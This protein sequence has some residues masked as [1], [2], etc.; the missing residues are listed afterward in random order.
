M[1]AEPITLT[2][3]RQHY[4]DRN[5]E[6]RR[7]HVAASRVLPGGNTRTLLFQPPFPLTFVRGEGS[8]LEDADGHR[9]VDLLGDY[10]AG[11]LGHSDHRARNAAF[12]ALATNMSVGGIHPIET[13]LA[14]LMCQRWELGLVRFTNSGTEANLMAISAA[15]M[16]TGRTHV[17]V[18]EGAYHGGVLYFGHGPAAWNAPYPVVLGQFNDLAA[19]RRAIA[20]AG[21]QLAAVLVEPMMGSAGCV[22]PADGF[23]AGLVDAAHEVGAVA[24]FDEVMTSRLGPHGLSAMS[25]VQP[26]LKTFGKYIAGGFS[27]G[28]FGGSA[29]V[30]SIFDVTKRGVLPHAGTFNN[31]V[32]SLAAAVEVLRNVYTSD[33][34]DTFTQRGDEFRAGVAVVLA[35]HDLPLCVTGVGTMMNLHTRREPPADGATAYRRNEALQEQIYLGLLERGFYVAPRLMINLS[36]PL[37]DD[38]LAA[39]LSALDEVCAEVAAG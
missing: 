1:R 21:S 28:A 25:G 39:F 12:A 30:M 22:P 24:I 17:M 19:C 18:V 20:E 15:R 38:Q 13:D 26:D 4:A 36:L 2:R 35:R 27:F 6:S 37:T 14:V 3:A 31:N 16:R 10:T 7:R 5:V 29:E 32:T 8:V 23:L 9:Y 34:A 33:V 11:L